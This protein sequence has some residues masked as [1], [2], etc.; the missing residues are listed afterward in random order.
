MIER[1]KTHLNEIIFALVN[2]VAGLI[3]LLITKNPVAISIGAD[4]IVGELGDK[5]ILLLFLFLGLLLGTLGMLGKQENPQQRVFARKRQI[6]INI[7][8]SFWTLITIFFLCMFNSLDIIGSRVYCNIAS[9]VV[10]LL[11]GVLAL[12]SKYFIT[13][14]TED[15]FYNFRLSLSVFIAE[16]AGYVL[17]AVAYANIFVDNL[18]FALISVL[19]LGLI[20][21]LIP[22]IVTNYLKKKHTE[23]LKQNE[24]DNNISEEKILSAVNFASDMISEKATSKKK[25][26]KKAEV[27]EEKQENEPELA[28]EV[29]RSKKQTKKIA[30]QTTAKSSGQKTSK[31][32]KKPA[33]KKPATKTTQK[34]KTTKSTS[35]YK[36]T[37]KTKNIK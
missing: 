27:V 33:T 35:N 15:M 37:S 20:I 14:Q 8:M 6:G 5:W 18:Y 22:L 21:Y 25:S 29:V 11:A 10:A 12:F 26:T 3:C 32:A 34:K 28:E 16:I 19:V 4:F 7:L 9:L 2:F 1:L 24:E 36:G 30:K 23:K 17:L 31:N 13:K